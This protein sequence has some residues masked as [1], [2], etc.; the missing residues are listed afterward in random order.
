M[1]SPEVDGT[2]SEIQQIE[3]VQARD[4]L[5]VAQGNSTQAAQMDGSAGNL[6]KAAGTGGSGGFKLDPQAAANL[7]AACQTAM[8]HIS[9]M[10]VDLQAISQ[11]PSLGSLSGA[12]TVANYT[13]NV[14][15]DP[16]GMV[17][18]IQSLNATLQQM[19]DAYVQASTNYQETNDQ[20]ADALKKIDP[21]QSSA[22]TGTTP[23]PN[24]GTQFTA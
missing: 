12:Q 2:G 16:Q 8:D 15:T 23:N 17:Q 1:Y 7:A 13:Q 21:G 11:A 18:A 14:A 20:I 5:A 10:Q 9:D 24:S 22:P 19:H 6:L 3:A 4:R